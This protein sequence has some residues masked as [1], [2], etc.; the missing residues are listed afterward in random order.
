MTRGEKLKL[1]RMN[2]HLT[3]EALASEIGY[4]KQ[5]VYKIESGEKEPC[6]KFLNSVIKY[7]GVPVSFFI[8]EVFDELYDD[9]K[10]KDLESILLNKANLEYKG[11]LLSKNE[12]QYLAEI[13]DDALRYYKK[14]A[15]GE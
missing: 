11:K 14:Y 13:L 9:I 3:R 10:Q 8:D 15:E 1:L 2:N 5:M 6:P 7:F 4:S 12:R